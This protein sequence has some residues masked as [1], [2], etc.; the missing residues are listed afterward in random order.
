MRQIEYI[1]GM[2][3]QLRRDYV[4]QIPIY[5][6]Q[7]E[8]RYFSLGKDG[9]LTIRK[10]YAWNGA[11]WPAIDTK[12]AM[13]PSLIHDALCQ[14]LRLGLLGMKHQRLVHDLLEQHC[15]EDG[16]WRWRAHIWRNTVI[17][18]NGGDVSKGPDRPSHFAP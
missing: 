2:K 17:A 12:S 18:A 5:G 6:E 9:T 16:M 13:R 8:H 4:V 14:A 10:S 1:K 3:Y 7:F 11:D 15:V